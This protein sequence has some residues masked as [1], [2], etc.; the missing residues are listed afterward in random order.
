MAKR[1]SKVGSST[2]KIGPISTPYVDCAVS[3]PDKAGAGVAVHDGIDIRGGAKGTRGEMP[4]VTL[5]DVEGG[6]P[7]TKATGKKIANRSQF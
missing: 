6:A 7:G 4:E 1:T 5:V 3:Q 2:K